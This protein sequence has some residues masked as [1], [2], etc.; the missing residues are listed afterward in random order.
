MARHDE[1]THLRYSSQVDQM[2]RSVDESYR[3][4]AY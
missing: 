4:F 1:R 3:R 2:P